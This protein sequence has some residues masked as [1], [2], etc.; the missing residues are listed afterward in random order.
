MYKMYNAE[1]DDDKNSLSSSFWSDGEREEEEEEEEVVVELERLT[2]NEDAKPAEETVQ[3]ER[4]EFN[5]CNMSDEGSRG[6]DEE[7]ESRSSTCES[8]AQRPMTSGYGTYRVDLDQFDQDSRGDLSELRDDEDRSV[9]SA[10][11]CED[12][13]ELVYSQTHL[14]TASAHARVEGPGGDGEAEAEA[15]AE[16]EEENFQDVTP[17][18]GR[19][20]SAAGG[21][22]TVDEEN[23]DSETVDAEPQEEEVEKEHREESDESSSNKDIKFI[24]SKVDFSPMMYGEMCE[25]R[26]GNLRRTTGKEW[27]L[28]VNGDWG[29]TS[30]GPSWDLLFLMVYVLT[31]IMTNDI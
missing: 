24:D 30:R 20:V 25:E 11:G 7:E 9:C 3:Q 31:I 2:G 28:S 1:S 10:A 23:L 15:E 21:G 4:Y 16:A 12:A 5:Q 17:E 14:L 19:H 13:V 27:H 26:E 8:P 22:S 29:V 6:D 18:G